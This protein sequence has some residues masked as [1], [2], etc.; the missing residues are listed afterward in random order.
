MKKCAF[1][2]NSRCIE[3][4]CN[5]IRVSINKYPCLKTGGLADGIWHY[6]RVLA[7]AKRPYH[8]QFLFGIHLYFVFLD[9]IEK[10]AILSRSIL[11][12]I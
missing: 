7:S 12:V 6:R 8:I 9:K 3:T 4:V 1:V 10:E 2:L 11:S 5:I